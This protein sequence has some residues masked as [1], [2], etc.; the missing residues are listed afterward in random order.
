[1]IESLR[2]KIPFDPDR[3]A[4]ILVIEDDP[5]HRGR[6]RTLLENER[7][8]VA[9]A[10]DGVRALTIARR[11]PFSLVILD[12]GL[13]GLDGRDLCR[14][15][16]TLTPRPLILFLT[17]RSA[18]MDRVQGLDCGADDYVIKPYSTIEL[19]A[20]VRA[21]LRRPPSAAEPWRQTVMAGSLLIDGAARFA[22]LG[23]RRIPLTKKEC[24]LLLCLSRHPQR[25]FSP[26]ELLDEVWGAAYAGFEHTVRSHV[27]RLR[28][29]LED[30]P[31]RPAILV[32]VRGTGYKFV[33]PLS[34]PA[35]SSLPGGNSPD[36]G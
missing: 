15:L 36:C 14:M 25:V 17:G 16:S 3:H 20:R 30:D 32:T 19:L 1:M 10:G 6:I 7:F 21:L 24:D 31:A 11:Q 28:S 4:C 2:G 18:E 35:R 9:T 12:H 23:T 22:M 5:A 29:K 33:T 34:T 26:L 27:N 13:P 8:A